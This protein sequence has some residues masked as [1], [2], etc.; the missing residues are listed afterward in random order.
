MT[1]LPKEGHS[2]EIGRLAGR[3]LGNKL[4]KTWIEKEL[5]G[6]SDFG[7]DYLIQ[8]K[9]END[10]VSFSF[11]LQ[12]KG[13]TAP[14]YSSEKDSIS[15][16]FKVSTLR[17]YHQQEP[18]I[19]VAVV[20]LEGNEDKLWKCPIYYKWLD[21]NWFSEKSNKLDSQ[22]TVSVKIP[23][24][25]LLN[26]SLDVYNFYKKRV[27]QK[28]AVAELKKEIESHSKDFVQS[29]GTLTEAISEKPVFL[30]TIEKYGDEPWVENPKDEVSTLL[31]QCS[32]CLG[33]NKLTKASEILAGLEVDKSNLTP[34]ENAEFYFQKA[35]VL[36]RQGKYLQAKEKYKRSKE[37]SDKDRY[38][39]A[40]IESNFFLNEKIDKK[41][42]LKIAES[43]PV[44][45]YR[46]AILKAKCLVLMGNDSDAL[47]I[48]KKFPEKIVGLLIILFIAD[49]QKAIDDVLS[50][51]NINSL[52][53]DQEKFIFHSM[54]ARRAFVEANH[55]KIPYGEV[56]PIQGFVDV[57]VDY[58]KEAYQN[59]VKAWEFA[60]ELGYP[61]DITVLLDISSLIF[62]Y[63]NCLDKLFYHFDQILFERPNHRDLI[64]IYSPLL[65]NCH[66][67]EK[68]IDL[69][70]RISSD[71]NNN[72]HE[73]LI[74]SFYNLKRFRTA[75]NLLKEQ[76]ENF[77]KGRSEKKVLL[78]YIGAE[79]AKEQLNDD[80]AEKYIKIVKEFDLGEVIICIGNFINKAND[81]PHKKDIYASELYD[82]YIRLEKPL[83]IAEQL[84]RDLNPQEQASA[85]QIVHLSENLMSCH[86]IFE[87]DYF[88]LAQALL[89]I[90]DYEGALSIANQ[91][92][93]K[94]FFDPYWHIIKAVSLQ[95]KG[96]LGLAFIEIKASLDDNRFSSEHL[97]Y[98]VNLCL[99]FGLFEELEDVLI[100]LLNKSTKRQ[101]K[102]SFLS[103]LI[104]IYSANRKEYSDKLVKAIKRFGKLVNRD[105]CT[106]EGQYL[107][108]F[109]IS[110]MN[111]SPHETEEFQKRL[112]D[113]SAK[114]PDSHILKLGKIDIDNG[115]DALLH[116]LNKMA[117]IS[118]EQIRKW[119]QNKNKIRNGQLPVPFVMLEKFLRD[120]NDLF[121]TWAISK[122]SHED[123][124][125]YKLNQSPQ[126]NQIK[127]NSIIK[128]NSN[129]IIEDSSLLILYEIGILRNFL[130]E[131]SEICILNSTFDRIRNNSHPVAGSL[132]NSIPQKILET[133]NEFKLKLR[134]ISEE[135]GNF[136]EAL[137]KDLKLNN[138]IFITDD[139]NLQRLVIL[140]EESI[141]SANSYNIIEHLYN[142]SIINDDEK[143][144]SISKICSFGI[145]QPNMS[146]KLLS[147]TLIYFTKSENGVNYI[148]TKF[149]DIFDKVFSSQRDIKNVIPLFY[150]TLLFASK[151]PNFLN[152][153]TLIPLFKGVL[154][155]HPYMD[156]I[157]FVALWFVQQCLS[158]KINFENE[159]ILTSSQHVKYW[160]VYIDICCKIQEKELSTY[161][162]LVN[163]LNQIFLFDNEVKVVA[164]Q[165]IK[166]CFVPLTKEAEL[167]EKIYNEKATNQI[168]NLN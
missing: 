41:K 73:M 9:D 100:D 4:P 119:E 105:D 163:V 92:I 136:I 63:F 114:F 14:L 147:D 5:D 97:K 35:A 54:V 102:L 158:T 109:M 30:K 56:I 162:L 66:Q 31:K 151:N 108:S 74:L 149:K 64:K 164:Y 27:K 68:V 62:G 159:L 10:H 140:G 58:M 47:K 148:D 125:E 75:L 8:L 44:H 11:Y 85:K 45:D 71:L 84:F 89:T 77:L 146:L 155:R 117:G 95:E 49:D 1:K 76:E 19:M 37:L 90:G 122:N 99:Q 24:T 86:N 22:K 152:P 142:Q 115:P 43:L 79:M 42:L 69:L 51:F 133:I 112:S 20:D 59:L 98:Y 165:N 96:K 166:S 144:T 48:M 91:H 167:L 87:Q 153:N 65:F 116:S 83:I 18:L 26:Q 28:F 46:N 131:I 13:S 120:T 61:S 126:L 53:N 138:S 124:L 103:N 145:H 72:E 132:H 130:D 36:S 7:I 81:E 25:Q 94:G 50:D 88:H 52:E 3:A 150:D 101:E 106:E 128:S 107:I 143:F 168:V 110:P 134:L 32:D 160:Q 129:I 38:K 154:L 2:Q 123:Q 121:T 29:I 17:Y 12:L 78:F 33:S 15:Y 34:H 82:D 141:I 93:E 118:E 60:K 135:N 157:P 70:D 67:F 16:D 111:P 127:Y 55:N 80:L 6:D 156:L 40:Y 57:K 137:K 23:T 139:L 113:Y 39:L 104:S 21:E 161:D